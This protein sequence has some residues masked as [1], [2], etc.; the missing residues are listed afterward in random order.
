MKFDDIFF[1]IYLV[2]F[3]SLAIGTWLFTRKLNPKQKHY[4]EPRLALF[5]IAIIGSL[6]LVPAL[7]GGQLQFVFVGLAAIIFIGYISVA[8]VRVNSTLGILINQ[9]Y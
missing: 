1:P 6:L 9:I 3:F 2:V 7:V 8:K 4:W 5:N